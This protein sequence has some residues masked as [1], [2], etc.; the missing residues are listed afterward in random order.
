MG[1]SCIL[2]KQIKLGKANPACTVTA[3]PSTRIGG[4]LKRAMINTMSRE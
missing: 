4:D 1:T 2:S 3:I